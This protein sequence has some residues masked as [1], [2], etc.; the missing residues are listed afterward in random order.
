MKVYCI[1]MDDI[2]DMIRPNIPRD[3]WIDWAYKVYNII[4]MVEWGPDE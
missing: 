4:Y 2:Q 1:D 3:Y